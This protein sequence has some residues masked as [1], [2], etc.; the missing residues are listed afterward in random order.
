MRFGVAALA[1]TLAAVLARP[2]L[3]R[4]DEDP[5]EESRAAFRRG[6]AAIEK[7]DWT[8]ARAE[9]ER[10]YALFPHPSILL[11][12]GLAR[13]R[14]EAWV[15]AE[16]ALVKFLADDAGAASDEVE[17]ARRTLVEVKSH[18]GTLRLEVKPA[19]ATVTL[20]GQPVTLVQG[21]RTEVRVVLGEHKLHAEAPAHAAQELGVA[22]PS[23][24]TDASLV[25]VPLATDGDERG[26]SSLQ[27]VGY[28]LLGVSAVAVGIGV[29][30]GVRALDLA[31]QYSTPGEARYQ[32]PSAKSTGVTFRTLA[33][34]TLIGGAVLAATGIVLAF[35][36]PK[37]KH[38]PPPALALGLGT[39][40]FRVTFE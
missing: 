40:S 33:D 6:V 1:L 2:G 30:A 31:H 22:I 32:D 27:I 34:V 37:P 13:A 16:T 7:Q 25:L 39:V 8:T 20:D 12:L 24:G 29:F 4:A 10:A 26:P 17:T 15:S 28:S 23:E 21:G 36:V 14:T 35:V 3:A 18:L 11:D 9:L 19:N 5:R 38:A